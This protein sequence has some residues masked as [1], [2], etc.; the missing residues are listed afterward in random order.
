MFSSIIAQNGAGNSVDIDNVSGIF[1]SQGYNLIGNADGLSGVSASNHDQ[2]G[3]TNVPLDPGLGTLGNYGGITQTL[4]ILIGS[5]AIQ[6]GSCTNISTDQRGQSRGN[7]C[8][9]GAYE[10]GFILPTS[11]PTNTATYVPTPTA[12]AIPTATPPLNRML[13]VTTLNDSGPGSLRDA[14]S[15]ANETGDTI[16]FQPGLSGTISLG[17]TLNIQADMT[18]QGPGEGV[19]TLDGA[20]DNTI[21]LATAQLTINNLTINNHTLHNQDQGISSSAML[22]V[23]HC[24]FTNNNYAVIVTN[25]SSTITDSTFLNNADVG[26]VVEGGNAVFSRDHFIGNAEGIN[27]ASGIATID[28]STFDGTGQGYSIGIYS[29]STTTV[30]QST[31]LNGTYGV[32]NASGTLTLENTTFTNNQY[33]VSVSGTTNLDNSTVAHNSGLGVAIQSGTS[34]LNM[35]SSIIAQNGPANN[36]DFVKYGGVVSSQGYNLI[37]NGDPLAGLLSSNHDQFGTTNMPLNAGLA[38]WVIMVA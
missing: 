1:S 16:M 32:L 7:P 36:V 29:P 11:T 26:V 38:R 17:S 10:S 3:T 22:T 4:P 33:G 28:N 34:S 35:L 37:G 24:T 31:F 27:N 18:I 19:I 2:Y 25:A 14:V 21:I 12:T 8:D 23:S 6:A 20:G 9:V 30:R 15:I 13:V 5:S